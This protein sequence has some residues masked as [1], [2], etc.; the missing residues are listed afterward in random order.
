MPPCDKTVVI[1]I[2]VP[3][4]LCICTLLKC[5]LPPLTNWKCTHPHHYL[6]LRHRLLAEEQPVA[7]V[8]M[9]ITNN[10]GGGQ[11]VSMQCIREVG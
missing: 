6:V 3:D 1:T 5:G 2:A 11:P 8:I 4:A 9:T 7:C 10:S